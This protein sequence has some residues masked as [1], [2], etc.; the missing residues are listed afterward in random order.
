M[1]VIFGFTAFGTQ[2]GDGGVTAYLED[3]KVPLAFLVMLILQFVLIIIDRALYLRKFLLG[4]VIFQYVL[5]LGIHIWMFLVLP[6]VTERSFNAKKPPVIWYMIK[7][8]YLLFS[9]YQIRC[10]YPTRI[11]GNFLTRSFSFFNSLAYKF[12]MMIPLLFEMRTLMDW[13]WTDTSMTLFDWLKMEDIFGNM[14]QL[15]CS[16]KF[17]EDFPAPRG[18]KKKTIVKYLMGGGM[19]FLLIMI[20][21]SPLGLFALGNTVG[22]PNPPYEVKISLKIGPYEPIYL[23]NAQGANIKQFTKNDWQKLNEPYKQDRTAVTFLSNYEAAD[24]VAFEL[25]RNST[26]IWS[27]SPPDR[28][29]MIDDIS[30]SKKI[31]HSLLYYTLLCGFTCRLHSDCPIQVRSD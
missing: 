3:N 26:S 17:E 30:S 24:V 25:G 4:K 12:Y 9:A 20:I 1:V 14:Y 5:V 6:K 11:L 2:Q 19:L 23:S 31:T 21:W 8:I 18:T 22:E 29:R 13:I 16:R 27:I 28:D 10:G 7:C 15:K